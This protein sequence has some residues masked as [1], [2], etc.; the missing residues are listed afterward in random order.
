MA[1]ACI[2]IREIKERGERGTKLCESRS[3]GIV[4]RARMVLLLPK[5]LH[6]IND[7]LPGDKLGLLDKDQ[8][9]SIYRKLSPLYAVLTGLL[10]KCARMTGPSRILFGWWSKRVE[11]ETERL[12]DILETLALGSDEEM[13]KHI[14]SAIDA[15]ES[16]VV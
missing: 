7:S 14:E 8:A 15:V 1:T 3:E 2:P 10:G 13:R 11:R 6:F 5:L 12:G 4:A 9:A 16:V